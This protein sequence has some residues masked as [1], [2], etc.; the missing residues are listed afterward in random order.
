MVT[1]RILLCLATPSLKSRKYL[2]IPRLTYSFLDF[3]SDAVEECS[4]GF[5]E[6]RLFQVSD[7]VHGPMY[8]QQLEEKHQ[9]REEFR[10]K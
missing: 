4:Y 2:W 9:L 3:G 6:Q 5:N 10:L 7:D 1:P 8:W